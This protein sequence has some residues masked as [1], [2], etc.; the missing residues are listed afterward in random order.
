MPRISRQESKVNNKVSSNWSNVGISNG[1]T[2]QVIG[3]TNIKLN[4]F[5]PKTLPINISV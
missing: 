1:K 3:K 5:D 4:K 2:N